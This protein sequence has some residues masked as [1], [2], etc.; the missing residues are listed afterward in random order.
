VFA[1]LVGMLALT[2]FA[3]KDVAYSP[4][5]W[6]QFGLGQEAARALRATLGVGIGVALLGFMVLLRPPL[7]VPHAPNAAVLAHAQAIVCAQDNASANL[8][9]L[10]DKSIMLSEEGDAFIMFA[11]QGSSFIA[12]GD[13][14][15]EP[16]AAD[17]LTWQFREMVS[18]EGGRIAFYQARS[19][20]LPTYLDMGLAPLK[21][22]EEAV[23]LLAGFSLEGRRNEAN[24]YIINRAARLGLEFEYVPAARWDEIMEAVHAV[25]DAW[26]VQ[27]KAREKRF[28]LGLFDEAYV[29]HFDVGV[30]HYAGRIVAFVTLLR[31]HTHVEVTTDLMRQL[32]DAP[33]DAMRFLL[34]KLML[35]MKAEGVQRFSLAM[36][37]LSGLEGHRYAPVWQRIGATIY[38]YGGAYY[39]FSGVRQFKEQFNP[40]W[41]PRYLV[42]QG[43]L[44]PAIILT[45]VAM[46]IGGGM[47]GVLGK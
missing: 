7:R 5:L 8:A 20:N 29:R 25:S 19:G 15:G 32:P 44:D 11:R 46:L 9:L 26:L 24:R 2:F 18:Q 41:E 40:Q 34:I 33:R 27:R 22:G 39:N 16:E 13:A 31:T 36:A 45:D 1:A 17:E 23:V 3:F 14:V 47:R 38:Q 6:W 42:T 10:G 4:L 37:P 43:G 30:L 21:I 35:K 12:L 28:S